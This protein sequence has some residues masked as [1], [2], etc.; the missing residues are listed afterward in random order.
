MNGYIYDE[1]R[2]IAT[3]VL[4]VK[5]CNHA[6]IVGDIIASLGTGEYIISDLEFNEGDI[7]PVDIND[8]RN[9]VEV[10]AAQ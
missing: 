5:K 4:N 6:T 1:N 7:L 2:K 8:R 10:L 9:E 3:K